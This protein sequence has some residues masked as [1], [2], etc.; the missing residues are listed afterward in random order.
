MTSNSVVQ[1]VVFLA[2]LLAAAVPLGAFMARVYSG[3]AHA[4]QR[5]F[6]PLERAFYRLAGVREDEEMSWKKYAGA[7]LLFNL[8]G[9]LVV[10]ALQRLQ[11]VAT[12]QPG[13]ALR[14]SLPRSRSIPRSASRPTP[15]GRLTAA[16]R[17]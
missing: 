13:G 9:A 16:R 3:E 12:A 8:L 2:F 14:P 4:A 5:V 1:I 15:T 11:G 6:G 17:P 10:Y 7:V